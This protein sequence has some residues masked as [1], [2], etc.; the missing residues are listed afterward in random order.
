M[1]RKIPLLP[2]RVQATSFFDSSNQNNLYGA[3]VR[4]FCK[5]LACNNCHPSN[6]VKILYCYYMKSNMETWVFK[7]KMFLFLYDILAI[8]SSLIINDKCSEAGVGW[9]VKT[10]KPRVKKSHSG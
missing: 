8:D 9:C 6:N 7:K 3:V 2:W 1:E 10:K 5:V 4:L